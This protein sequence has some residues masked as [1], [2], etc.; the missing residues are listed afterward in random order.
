M[1][2]HLQIL[3]TLHDLVVEET[4]ETAKVLEAGIAIK[5]FASYKEQVGR[6]FAY[7]RVLDLFEEA[8]EKVGKSE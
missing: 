8:A 6:I 1:S 3:S 5:D 4:K 2:Y 7:K